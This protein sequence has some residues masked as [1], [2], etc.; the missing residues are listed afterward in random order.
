[1][2]FCYACDNIGIN[3]VPVR[4]I[5]GMLWDQGGLSFHRNVRSHEVS[6]RNN[7]F[8]RSLS[9]ISNTLICGFAAAPLGIDSAVQAYD[10]LFRVS[11]ILCF[12]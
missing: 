6:E 4:S 11:E 8:R 3:K 10:T 2:V 7:G 1:M 12:S 5:F 9:P